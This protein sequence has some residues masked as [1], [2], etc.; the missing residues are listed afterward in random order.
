MDLDVAV[1]EEVARRAEML[2]VVVVVMEAPAPLATLVTAAM[3]SQPQTS[4][5]VRL[6]RPF[7]FGRG[8][9]RASLGPPAR[10]AGVEAAP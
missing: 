7:L 8:F 10:K 6:V 4:W 3:P 5:K 2:V 9:A 1:T